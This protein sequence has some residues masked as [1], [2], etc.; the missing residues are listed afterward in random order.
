M[1]ETLDRGWTSQSG[2]RALQRCRPR[3][4]RGRA[5]S[6]NLPG[7]SQ[8]PRLTFIVNDAGEAFEAAALLQKNE[9]PK[10]DD[11]DALELLKLFENAS[12]AYDEARPTD[13]ARC[14]QEMVQ[15]WMKNRNPRAAAP[16]QDRLGDLYA[17]RLG[18]T[19]KAIESWQKAGKWYKNARHIS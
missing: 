11:D 8:R 13:S 14:Q 19:D 5:A 12:Q 15:F 6:V 17:K 9:F 2:A 18:D 4:L 3:T 7:A 10:T 16:I 1:V